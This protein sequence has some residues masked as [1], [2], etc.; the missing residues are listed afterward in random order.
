[1]ARVALINQAAVPTSLLEDILVE[2]ALPSGELLLLIGDQ[3]LGGESQAVTVPRRFVKEA[4]DICG[5]EAHLD[6]LWE[7]GISVGTTWA[8]RARGF[9]AYFSYLLGHELGHASTIL[10]NPTLAVYEDML[11]RY[12]G[13]AAPH[14]KWRWMELPHEIRYD[15]FGKAVAVA[16]HG[17]ETLV[18][19]LDRILREGLSS[20]T[21]RL[22]LIRAAEPRKDL[23]GLRT[24]LARFS[25]PYRD[26]LLDLWYG[27][28]QTHQL[29]IADG[30]EDLAWLWSVV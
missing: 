12:I 29:R 27:A 13:Q 9:P 18:T 7:C 14:K 8:D 23:G 17:A 15:Q 24:D 11:T 1:M 20:D 16:I 4:G 30:I 21:R 5:L 2:A 10:A 6:K 26:K 3:L 22:D 25:A 28:R 19:E